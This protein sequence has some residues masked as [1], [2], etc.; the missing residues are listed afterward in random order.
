M[1]ADIVERVTTLESS[2]RQLERSVGDHETRLRVIEEFKAKS[3]AYAAVGSAFG[4]MI[5]GAIVAI[6]IKVLT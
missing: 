5:G 1:A 3:L 6:A 2:S 4:S